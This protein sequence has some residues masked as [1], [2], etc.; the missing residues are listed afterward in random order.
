MTGGSHLILYDGM[1]GLC[2]RLVGMVLKRDHGGIF[3]F[4][5][6]QSGFGRDLVNRSGH[7][8]DVLET[9]YVLP[10]YQTHLPALLSRADAA[11]FLL[12]RIGGLWRAL[13]V[14]SVLPH[15][16]LDWAYD[17]IARN[18]YGLFGRYESCFVP[19]TEYR[20]RFLDLEQ[21]D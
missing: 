11:L 16:V 5:S 3:R 2:R 10:D 8:P 12:R 4:A 20:D 1:C 15:R 7:D 17:L 6:L 21:E 13:G 9:F 14:L 18:R 19:G